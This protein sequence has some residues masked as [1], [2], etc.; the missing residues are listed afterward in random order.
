MK[1]V[2]GIAVSTAKSPVAL[3][4][5]VGVAA[6]SMVIVRL[7]F[8]TEVILDD[9]L[10]A[11]FFLSFVF[12]A[13]FQN[14]WAL[15]PLEKYAPEVVFRI[16]TSQPLAALTID[17]VPL[18]D[19]P[20]SLEEILDTLREH[21]VRATFFIMSGFDL[22]TNKGGMDD[23]ARARCRG[24]LKRAVA[25]GHEL[26]NHLQFDKPAIGMTKEEFDES[27]F[28]CDN[29]LAEISGGEDSW[30]ARPRRWFR[31]ASA[32]WNEHML[33]RAREKGYTTVIANCY[34]HD[35]AAVTRHVNASYLRARVRPGAVIVVH[36]RWHTPATLAKA[37]PMI[38]GDGMR[39]GTLSELQRLSDSE[40]G[41]SNSKKPK[42]MGKSG[43]QG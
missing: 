28:H 32:L 27:F 23:E 19:N 10:L 11:L 21:K 16:P 6:A 43:K 30:R 1:T 13:Y 31:P 12:I 7:I 37:L 38:L 2:R 29:F 40:T 33:Q 9:L 34:P 42:E 35:V 14:D 22:P 15:S 41:S 3:A 24:L 4:T 20:S 26:A 25:E 5:L 36:D 8:I 18:L 39:L 17:D